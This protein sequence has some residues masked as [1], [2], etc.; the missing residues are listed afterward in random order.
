MVYIN[1]TLKRLSLVVEGCKIGTVADRTTDIYPWVDW[2][3]VGV[4]PQGYAIK[5]SVTVNLP[6]F[7]EGVFHIVQNDVKKANQD[8][9]DLA[10]FTTAGEYSRLYD[11]GVVTP[12]YG[13]RD[14]G[15]V[16]IAKLDLHQ[17]SDEI[18]NLL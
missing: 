16:S 12:Y 10:S 15:V 6:D 8:R 5:R 7:Q 13:F 2:V 17:V 1:H 3:D 11:D 14:G 18:K 4:D 9:K